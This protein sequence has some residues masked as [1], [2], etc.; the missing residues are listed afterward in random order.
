VQRSNT[1]VILFSLV[2]TIILGGLLS[3][4][5]V[6]LRPAQKKAEEFAKKRQILSAVLDIKQIPDI[7]SEYNSRITSYIVNANGETVEQ[8][9]PTGEPIK[10]EDLDIEKE[11]KK[12]PGDRLYPV[13]KFHSEGSPD[14]IEA[15]ILAMYGKGLWNDI[16]GYIAL[17]TD[18][19]TV[20][21]IVFDHKGE[22][23]G[24]GSRITD[25]AVQERYKGKKIFD[26][27]GVIASV[28]M[29]KGENNKPASIDNHNINGLSGATIT[30]KGVNYMMIDYLNCY[31]P[32]IE[33]LKKGDAGAVSMLNT[34]N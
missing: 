28:N 29:L 8:N 16:W 25:R 15:Y 21:G 7:V 23:A 32:L 31:L 34:K 27:S 2:L 19:N 18:M 13:Y 10:A 33:N 4:A 5:S 14:N 12:D 22:T 24:L 26:D 17:E 9:G 30:A 11:F 1:Y 20:A 6:G 3:L